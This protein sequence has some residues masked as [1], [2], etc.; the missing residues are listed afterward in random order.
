MRFN[1]LKERWIP[2]IRAD[3]SRDVIA[4]WEITGGD[5]PPVDLA[6]P[7]PDFRA[8]LLE[9]LIGLLQTACA[10]PRNANWR[11]LLKEPPPPEALRR[12][13]APHEPY[14]NLFGDKP[15]FMQDF[16]LTPDTPNAI[17]NP[18]PSLLIDSPNRDELKS[19][20]GFFN[21]RTAQEALCPACA[22]MALYAMQAFAP[23]GG[24]G[25]LASMRGGGPLST[26]VDG[27]TLWHKL[28]LNVLPQSTTFARVQAAPDER[29]LRGPVYAWAAPTRS[30]KDGL[31]THPD[32]VHFLQVFWGLPRRIVLIPEADDGQTECTLCGAKGGTVVRSFVTRPSGTRFGPEW[33]HPL[34][35]YRELGQ[36]KPTLSVKGAA[37]IAG[38]GNWLGIVYGQAA[39]A[40][41]RR[42]AAV[43]SALSLLWNAPPDG[44]A[45]EVCAAG[46]DQEKMKSRQWCESRFPCYPVDHD[47]LPEFRAAVDML[48]EATEAV[49]R[50]LVG[51]LKEALVNEAGRNQAKVDKTRFENAGA[52][53]WGRTEAEFYRLARETAGTPDLE[54]GLPL[55]QGWAALL[56][57]TAREL[58]EEET[59]RGRVK[60][61][62]MQRIV[63]AGRKLDN[64]NRKKLRS[65]LQLPDTG[66]KK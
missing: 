40:G 35:P 13:L 34:T 27:P 5:P 62:R 7:R 19:G 26:V 48:I 17:P 23:E 2:V 29:T 61:E 8:A 59:L 49:R 6:P 36:N 1:L 12:V 18:A 56:V 46:Y 63:E 16:E 47:R 51:L 24:R 32:D 41:V 21:K 38:Y 57:R 54:A 20:R 22:A 64:F 11:A 10:P 52:A 25:N 60:P 50:N 30:C 53:L 3:G 37:N 45:P 43:D 28:W 44:W 55:R 9:L 66:G 4:P 42:A 14:F 39:A 33:R 15:L 65:V 31:V 58:F